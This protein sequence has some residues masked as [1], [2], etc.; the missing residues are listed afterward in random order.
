MIA[1]GTHGTIAITS[2]FG[3]TNGQPP[4][5]SH[6]ARLQHAAH[7]FPQPDHGERHRQQVHSEMPDHAISDS[8]FTTANNALPAEQRDS[9]QSAYRRNRPSTSASGAH[10][11][12]TSLCRAPSGS[13]CIARNS[14]GSRG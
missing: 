6:L 2:R 3:P 7:M 10:I 5:S 12:G 13:I 14:T 9:F 1:T 11:D 8:E 4:V